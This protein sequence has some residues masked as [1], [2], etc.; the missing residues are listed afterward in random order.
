MDDN[1]EREINR[2][3]DYP[4]LISRAHFSRL[5][6]IFSNNVPFRARARVCVCIYNC[7]S[8]MRT[9]YF[10]YKRIKGKELRLVK[11]STCVESCLLC[12]PVASFCC[13]FPRPSSISA[14]ATTSISRSVPRN[15]FFLAFLVHKNLDEKLSYIATSRR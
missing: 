8:G 3:V 1:I 10:T 14:L 2:R 5:L 7:E 4:P 12:K 15:R 13:R 9:R 6:S 11:H